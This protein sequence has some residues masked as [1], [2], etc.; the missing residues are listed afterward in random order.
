[1]LLSTFQHIEGIGKKTEETLWHEGVL[2]WEQYLSKFGKQLSLLANNRS[3]S[4]SASQHAFQIGDVS[5]FANHLNKSEYYRVALA[6]PRETLFLD[7]ETT[8][9]SLY[10]DEITIIGWSIDGEYGVYIKDHDEND[11]IEALEKAKV[12]VTYNGTMFDLKF[13]KKKFPGISIPPVHVDLRFLAK[14]VGYTGG[15]KSIEKQIGFNRTSSIGDM[16]GEAAPILWHKYRR[17]DL[18]SL[19]QL[20]IYNHADIEGVKAIFDISV[21]GLYKLQDIPNSVRAKVKFEDFSNT[22]KWA[23]KYAKKTDSYNI[24][25]PKYVGDSSALIHYNDLDELNPLSE[26]TVIGI[27]LVSSEDRET[28]YCILKGNIAETSRVK[29]DEEMIQIAKENGADLISIDSPLSIP[30]G[31]T[32]FFDDDPKRDEFGIVR[33]CERLMKRRGINSYPCLIPS[34]QKLTQRGML[35]AEK[36]RKEGIDVIES[37][38]GAAQDIMSIP[39]KQAGLEY[40]KAG[41]HEFGIDGYYVSNEVS[42]DELDAITSAIVGLFFHVGMYEALGN[43]DEAYL[44]IPDLNSRNEKWKNKQVTSARVT[45]NTK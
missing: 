24:K 15:Q 43:E 36:F 8:G 45:I 41:L 16:L 20:I 18:G 30:K 22:I 2:N 32:S 12:I 39:R 31:R 1:M 27:D 38:P 29:T 6:Y 21:S 28:G 23:K 37:Y 4:I 26:L 9:L 14:R 13:I 33:V 11:L 5:Y 10:Y 40:L 44:V 42:H 19:K 34:M 35:L 3:N 17:G 7:I 25:I